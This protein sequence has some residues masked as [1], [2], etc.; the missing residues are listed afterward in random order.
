M[1]RGKKKKIKKKIKNK[2]VKQTKEETT[3]LRNHNRIVL[4]R[5]RLEQL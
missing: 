2:R 3:A 1:V 5:C 4:K